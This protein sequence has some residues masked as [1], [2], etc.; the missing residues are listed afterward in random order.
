[1][2][3]PETRSEGHMASLSSPPGT[4]LLPQL[5]RPLT[6]PGPS[7]RGHQQLWSRH[8]PMLRECTGG[9]VGR[10]WGGGLQ[11]PPD[12]RSRAAGLSRL[13]SHRGPL[14]RS[15]HSFQFRQETDFPLTIS[16]GSQETTVPH[17]GCGMQGINQGHESG[18]RPGRWSKRPLKLAIL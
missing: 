3:A 7:K 18:T 6:R 12:E 15:V 16:E 1:M 11:Q 8:A 14:G 5:W 17:F 13:A 2:P 10:P 4:V 9:W